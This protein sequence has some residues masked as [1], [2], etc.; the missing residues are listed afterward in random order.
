MP[1]R[2]SS[3]SHKKP[4]VSIRD[5][6]TLLMLQKKTGYFNDKLVIKK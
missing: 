1:I 5:R 4:R 2:K 3:K 6:D